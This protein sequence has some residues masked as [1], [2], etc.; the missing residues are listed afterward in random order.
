MFDEGCHPFHTFPLTAFR[1]CA[2]NDF[3]P[4][5]ASTWK[6]YRIDKMNTSTVLSRHVRSLFGPT[7][8]SSPWG[9]ICD[10]WLNQSIKPRF[11]LWTSRLIDWL[12]DD[13]LTLTWLVYWIPTARSV[14]TGAGLKWPNTARQYS[15]SIWWKWEGLVFTKYNTFAI[16]NMTCCPHQ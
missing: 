13:K 4:L 15:T 14:F 1:W 7:R 8:K 9:N 16:W 11:S 2:T 10:S 12:I 6:V 5:T 3:D